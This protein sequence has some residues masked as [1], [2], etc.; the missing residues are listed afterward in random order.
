[1]STLAEVYK[2]LEAT[3]LGQKILSMSWQQRFNSPLY[4]LSTGKTLSVQ[5]YVSTSDM[6]LACAMQIDEKPVYWWISY[7]DSFGESLPPLGPGKKVSSV[8]NISD[9]VNQT[10]ESIQ[11]VGSGQSI[12][13]RLILSNGKTIAYSSSYSSTNMSIFV[14][15]AQEI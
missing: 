9:C 13:I 10:I 1:M 8:E 11:M 2:Q 4:S 12:L 3:L 14:Y 6:D 5:V 7:S 15:P